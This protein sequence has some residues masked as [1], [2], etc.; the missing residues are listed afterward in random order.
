MRAKKNICYIGK[1]LVESTNAKIIKLNI[2][3][4]WINRTRDLLFMCMN[5]M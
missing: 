5:F 2:V 1:F 3:V 4:S